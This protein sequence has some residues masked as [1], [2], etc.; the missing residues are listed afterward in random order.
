MRH[1]KFQVLEWI[2]SKTPMNRVAQPEEISPLIAFLA[3]DEAAGFMT[4][5]CVVIDGDA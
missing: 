3:S 4:G 5:Q 2:K 1:L